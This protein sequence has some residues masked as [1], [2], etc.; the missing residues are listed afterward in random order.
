MGP[1]QVLPDQSRPVS[2]GNERVLHF[3][4]SSRTRAS[5]SDSLVLYQGQLFGEGEVLVLCKVQSAYSTAPADWVVRI[6][7]QLVKYFL[8]KWPLVPPQSEQFSTVYFYIKQ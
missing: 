2:N 4:Q 5:P 6:W 3:P 1:S 8:Q 7:A